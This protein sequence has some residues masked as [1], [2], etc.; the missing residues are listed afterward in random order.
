MHTF[1]L[2]KMH[3]KMSSKKWQEYGRRLSVL[4]YWHGGCSPCQSHVATFASGLYSYCIHISMVYCRTHTIKRIPWPR[5][6]LLILY[7]VSFLLVNQRY[8]TAIG[9]CFEKYQGSVN[10]INGTFAC[11]VVS[12]LSW[13]LIMDHSVIKHLWYSNII[14]YPKLQ[15][16][17]MVYKRFP[18]MQMYVERK[19]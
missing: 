15:Q 19:P 17:A 12:L 9:N 6:S 1:P 13:C 18:T 4:T 10:I 11:G 16:R 5:H 7:F 3:L 2:T 8:T 14:V